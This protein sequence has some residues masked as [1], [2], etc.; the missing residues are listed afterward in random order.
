M[1]IP[2]IETQEQDACL[3]GQTHQGE[4]YAY[5]NDPALEV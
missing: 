4:Q 5:S 3:N 2:A 1:G